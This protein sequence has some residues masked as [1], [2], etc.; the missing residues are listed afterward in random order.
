MALCELAG[1]PRV[2]APDG[3]TTALLPDPG[4]GDSRCAAYWPRQPGWHLL[5]Q[6]DTETE[7]ETSWPFFVYA[8][9]AAPGLR[10]ADLRDSAWRLQAMAVD[11]AAKSAD[12][13][14]QGRRGSS[15]PW[16]LA[17]LASAGVLWWLERA[18]AG[19]SKAAGSAESTK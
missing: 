8:A 14:A 12:R 10:A 19:R 1:K 15:W 2:V 4:A 16:F 9:D 3:Q 17:W 5:L 6:T 13:Q 7:R 18:R 11:T